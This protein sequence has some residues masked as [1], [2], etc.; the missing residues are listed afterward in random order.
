MITCAAQAQAVKDSTQH[1]NSTFTSALDRLP[2]HR[3]RQ[4][5]VW[6]SVTALHWLGRPCLADSTTCMTFSL[7]PRLYH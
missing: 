4:G 5:E 3:F 6:F 7:W 1:D 2:L